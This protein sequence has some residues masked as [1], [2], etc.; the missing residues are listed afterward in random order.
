[1]AGRQDPIEIFM[2]PNMLK[3]KVGGD[4]SLDLNA[5]NR[6]ERALENLKCE[7]AGWLADDV[8]RMDDAYRAYQSQPSARTLAALYRAG[9]DLR[10]QATTFEYP[11]VARIATSLCRLTDDSGPSEKLPVVLIEAHVAA[12]RVVV[13]QGIKDGADETAVLLVSE[14][15]TKVGEFLAK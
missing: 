4:G 1:M 15:E 6:A 11:L 2:P 7:F 3:A 8:A 14:L 10:G 5:V 13:R 12:I 9:H